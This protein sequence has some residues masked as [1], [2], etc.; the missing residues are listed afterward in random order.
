[1]IRQG[2]HTH[3]GSIIRRT[4]SGWRVRT[5][6]G[7]TIMTKIHTEYCRCRACKP[8]L[9]VRPVLWRT[10]WAVIALC[11]LYALWSAVR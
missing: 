4:V 5:N 2:T 11:G 3:H 6:Q 7:T 9:D 10:S 8:P 1:M